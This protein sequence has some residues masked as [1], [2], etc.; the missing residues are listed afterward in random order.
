MPTY[1][2]LTE[3]GQRNFNFKMTFCNVDLLPLLLTVNLN[4]SLYYDLEY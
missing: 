2:D 4:S 3:G 1:F